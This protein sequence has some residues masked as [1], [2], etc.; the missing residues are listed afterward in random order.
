ME[1]RHKQ[2][3]YFTFHASDTLIQ[4]SSFHKVSVCR[5]LVPFVHNFL[6]I[7]IVLAV[8]YDFR[9]QPL[10]EMNDFELVSIEFLKL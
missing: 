8:N 1:T 6:G 7:L 2:T 5:V 9:V 10:I 3:V 4:F